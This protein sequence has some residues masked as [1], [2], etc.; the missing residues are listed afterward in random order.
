MCLQNQLLAWIQPK[1]LQQPTF[2]NALSRVES[3]QAGRYFANR[4]EWLN[5]WAINLEV[6][7]PQITR[8]EEHTSELQSR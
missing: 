3:Q 7:L 4:R 2:D 8:S 5:R 6:F 1:A